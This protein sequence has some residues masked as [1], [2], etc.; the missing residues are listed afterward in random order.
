ME[1]NLLDKITPTYKDYKIE[2]IES[3]ASRRLFY[4]LTKDEKTFICLDSGK[5]KKAYKDF[6]KIHSYLSKVDVSIPCIYEN[7]D[8]NNNNSNCKSYIFCNIQYHTSLKL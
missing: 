8:N 5:E 2:K 3:G 4:R 1:H 7:D 6:I